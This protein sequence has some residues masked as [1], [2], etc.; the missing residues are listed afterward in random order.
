MKSV[1]GSVTSPVEPC[2]DLEHPFDSRHVQ[3]RWWPAPVKCL[4][5]GENP[6]KPTSA[7]ISDAIHAGTDPVG[8][9]R[10]LL[11]ALVDANLIVAPTLD[12]FKA[13][14]F[15]FDH[16]VRCQ[17]PTRVVTSE[18]AKARELRPSIA[19]AAGHLRDTARLAHT[20]W[21]MG[22]IARAAVAS[23]FPALD[24]SPKPLDP[25]Y[26]VGSK[27]FVS[28]YFRP[29]FDTSIKVKSIVDRF[30]AFSHDIAGA[31]TRD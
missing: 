1:D 3:S 8:V 16:G 26:T 9:R 23:Q 13:A 17:L 28:Q 31:T 19:D 15:V 25:P 10:L 20:V 24:F 14:G 5:I 2:C 22:T 18:R 27:F 30:R 12:A 11:P 7:Y 4:I 6:G 29:R 21:V